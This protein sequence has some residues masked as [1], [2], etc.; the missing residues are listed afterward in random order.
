MY[1]YVDMK[2]C[3]PP[4]PPE[5][6]HA[7]S[8]YIPRVPQC[9]SP[10]RNWDSPTP[11]PAS[12]GASPPNQGGGHIRL[13]VRGWGS[14]NSDDWNKSLALCLLCGVMGG[15]RGKLQRSEWRPWR[16]Y[17]KETQMKIV[18][19][20]RR[21]TCWG[22]SPTN[23]QPSPSCFLIKDFANDD[24]WLGFLLSVAAWWRGM[25]LRICAHNG[26]QI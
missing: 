4:L 20:Y 2:N 8:T 12:K 5:K 18:N 21:A 6:C 11:S 19:I 3:C 24:I 14:P 10:R 23:H 26:C 16:N 7:Q 15:R 22:G 25:I 13:R 9:M 1:L 17:E